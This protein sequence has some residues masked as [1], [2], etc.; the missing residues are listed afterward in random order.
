MNKYFASTAIGEKHRT[1]TNKII[2]QVLLFLGAILLLCSLI[3]RA[4]ASYNKENRYKLLHDNFEIE[5]QQAFD[6]YEELLLFMEKNASEKSEYRKA[7]EFEKMRL[8]RENWKVNFGSD[9]L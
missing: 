8:N 1:K 2:V 7:I 3:W 4:D 9:F 5:L 6:R